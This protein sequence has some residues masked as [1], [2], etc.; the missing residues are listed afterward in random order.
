M[1]NRL[2][3]T[4]GTDGVT[5]WVRTPDGQRFNLGAISVL[6]FVSRLV[7]N[8]T[9]KRVLDAF[10][11]SGEA[12]VSVDPDRMWDLLEPRRA[13]WASDGPFMVSDQRT[14]LVTTRAPFMHDIE[15]HLAAVEGHIEALNRQAGRAA[16]AHMAKGVDILVKLA[17]KVTAKDEP[18]AQEEQAEAAPEP[19]KKEEKAEDKSKEASLA[20]DIFAANQ[21]IANVILAKAESTVQT[22][23][24]LV[25]AGRPFNAARAKADVHAVTSKVAGILRD[26]DLTASWVRTDLDKLAARAD[27]LHGLFNPKK[28]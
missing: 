8:S 23:D 18:E 16:P 9:A 22:I 25:S 24:S 28:A 10:L 2:L 15:K 12:M 11:E 26:T 21:E 4:I 5:D 7:P 20:Y 14:T 6:S 27:H 19:E 13:I 1:S 3:V 17:A